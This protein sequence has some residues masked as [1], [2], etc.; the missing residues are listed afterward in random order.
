VRGNSSSHEQGR[1]VRLVPAQ[2]V[3][4]YV[5]TKKRDFPGGGSDRRS[6]T[7]AGNTFCADEE[8][9][10]AGSVGDASQ[11]GAFGDAPNGSGQR[12]GFVTTRGLLPGAKRTRYAIS[13]K[14]PTSLLNLVG[15]RVG[16]CAPPSRRIEMPTS[17][18]SKGS[19]QDCKCGVTGQRCHTRQMAGFRSAR[20]H[21]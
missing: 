20:P 4:P 16:E 3:K 2:D 7:M 1:P 18:P 10:A 21:R 6:G 17:Q 15:I 5:Q 8:R 9:E 11:A 19:I 13:P 14:D 12:T